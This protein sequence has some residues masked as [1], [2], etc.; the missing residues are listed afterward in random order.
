MQAPPRNAPE[1]GQASD[2]DESD[3]TLAAWVRRGTDFARS[4]PP[5]DAA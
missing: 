3:E 2:R 4:L 1:G 5:K